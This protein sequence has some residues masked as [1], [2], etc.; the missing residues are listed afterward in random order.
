MATKRLGRGLDGLLQGL[1]RAGRPEPLADGAGEASA[2]AVT[3]ALVDGN[4]FQPRQGMD[5][6]Q[7]EGLKASIREHGILQPIMVRPAGSRYQVVAGERRLRA[8]KELGLTEVPAVVREVPDDRM[9]EFALI[10]NLQREDL[11][12]IEKAESFKTYLSST[13]QTQDQAAGRLGL[14]RSTIAN[15]IRLLELPDE[16]QALVRGG[17]VAMGHA[18]A[19]LAIED[20]KRQVS[21]AERVVRE[22]LSVRQVERLVSAVAPS[23]RARKRKEKSPGVRDLEARLREALGTKVSVEEGPKAGAGRIIIEFYSHAD[24]DRILAILE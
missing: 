22:G 23:K 7:L 4:P 18:R 11:D 17:M 16:V 14:D 12:P 15:M 21:V 9:L 10:E 20:R 8:A 3:V 13:K 1:A 19:L 2:A 24:V 6:G 5:A